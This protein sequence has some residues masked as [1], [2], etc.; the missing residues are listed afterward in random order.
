M[1]LFDTNN[2]EVES[3]EAEATGIPAFS[4]QRP[5]AQVVNEQHVNT[6]ASSLHVDGSQTLAT[7]NTSN[8]VSGVPPT[9][10]S[11]AASSNFL[12]QPA[13]TSCAAASQATTPQANTTT[14]ASAQV[15]PSFAPNNPNALPL[16]SVTTGVGVQ[17]V[18]NHYLTPPVP[19][20][21]TSGSPMD[22]IS[23]D[24][25]TAN[26]QSN[27][28]QT[29]PSTDPGNVSSGL[30]QTSQT[31][32]TSPS[33]I[34]AIGHPATFSNRGNANANANM[35]SLPAV[36]TNTIAGSPIPS[37]PT[38]LRVNN[39]R[40]TSLAAAD[41][42]MSTLTAAYQT[43]HQA[44]L[45]SNQSRAAVQVNAN[46][47][48]EASTSPNTNVQ[49][50]QGLGH[51]VNPSQATNA[52]RQADA[53]RALVAQVNQVRTTSPRI[54]DP[55]NHAQGPFL[56]RNDPVSVE[57]SQRLTN[58]RAM[59]EH[60]HQVHAAAVDDQSSLIRLN[61]QFTLPL[62]TQ[63]THQPID[64]QAANQGPASSDGTLQTGHNAFDAMFQVIGDQDIQ[65][66]SAGLDNRGSLIPPRPIQFYSENDSL[67]AYL[68]RQ[69]LIAGIPPD[70]V[71]PM[72]SFSTQQR[73]LHG[74][75]MRAC[76][77][78]LIRVQR[79]TG[80]VTI[81]RIPRARFNGRIDPL[82]F[83]MQS[84][85]P[86]LNRNAQTTPSDGSALQPDENSDTSQGTLESAVE[87]LHHVFPDDTQ[88]TTEN[89]VVMDN[90]DGNAAE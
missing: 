2:E 27:I 73:L 36:Q 47:G 61:F 82:P 8:V 67:Q 66:A 58:L 40:G 71:V 46:H 68:I 22:G 83:D 32:A 43:Y 15:V 33:N 1:D 9:V 59:T 57:I 60:R 16:E 34:R 10:N 72:S 86:A 62:Q 20:I 5:S 85:T 39:Q 12:V 26:I 80:A 69:Q 81:P 38:N 50:I 23:Y 19:R 21:D 3:T 18:N 7:Q 41:H 87:F 42:R 78:A 70:E 84:F 76:D 30:C 48:V 54:P 88:Q 44:Y 35:Q 29:A 55:L 4:T 25:H 63:S 14:L 74:G 37:A 13:R 65:L 79:S 45:A 51:A 28:S 49:P 77:P 24:D 89:D 75:P 17:S 52:R 64:P 56:D 6:L 53:L 31:V 90:F 11:N